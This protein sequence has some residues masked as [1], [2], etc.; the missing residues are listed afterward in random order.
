MA[1]D[2]LL[3]ALTA[4]LYLGLGAYFWH[5]RWRSGR[6]PQATVAWEHAAILVPLGLHTWLLWT[7]LFRTPELHFGFGLALSVTLWLGVLIY[8]VESLYINLQGM[9]AVILPLAALCAFVPAI[10]PGPVTPAYT[11]HLAFRAH[12]LLAM[13]AYSLFTIGALHALLMA[14]LE[15]TL[16][17]DL[18]VSSR[19]GDRAKAS[20]IH[21]AMA[22]MPPLLTLERLLFRILALGF[23]LL[24]LTL[25]S[26]VLFSEEVFHQPLQFN[27]KIVFAFL[28]W[29][30]FGGL[31]IGRWR[32]G[33]RGRRALRWTV[34]GFVVLLLAYI[35]TRFVLEVL[36]QRP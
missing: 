28:S 30:I 26:G 6:T 27:H 3:H 7:A 12:L 16:H 33:W 11:H 5:S 23:V 8:W 10:F 25:G 1:S 35:G 18:P 22:G 21:G 32:Y 17:G 2:I 36:L 13:A 9:H 4:A 34:A 15:R 14:A 29:F 19:N 24:T 20:L 31:L